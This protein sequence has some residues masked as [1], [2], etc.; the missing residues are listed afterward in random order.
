MDRRFLV[1]AAFVVMGLGVAGWIL[2]GQEPPKRKRLD[3][4]HVARK[5]DVD[6]AA[7][8]RVDTRQVARAELK[9]RLLRD[10]NVAPMPP[11]PPRPAPAA[12]GP[13]PI[14]QDGVA[15]AVEERRA[16]LEACFQAARVHDPALPGTLPL[17][18]ALTTPPGEGVG[19]VERLTV[20]LD[21]GEVFA[22]CASPVFAT[23]EFAPT[24]PATIRYAVVFEPAA[25]P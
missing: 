16:D 8:R 9:E 2:L 19:R 4:P 12:E 13:Y 7:L 10:G 1:V 22:D 17:V 15:R 24:D 14:D 20:S 6:A 5:I 11:R 3:T 18:F 21:G 25:T 23:A